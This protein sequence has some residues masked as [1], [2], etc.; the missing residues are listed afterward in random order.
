MSGMGLKNLDALGAWS[1]DS[2]HKKVDVTG[3]GDTKVQLDFARGVFRTL[4][5]LMKE[6]KITW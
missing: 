6:G 4:W 3:R 2:C 1:C 5:I